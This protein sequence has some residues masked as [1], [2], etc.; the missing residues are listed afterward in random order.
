MSNAQGPRV[1]PTAVI[2]P[3]AELAGD[4]E[5]GPYAI[6]EGRVRVGPG[7]VIR[8][9]ALLCGP[10]TMGQNNQVFTGA[11]LG[12]RPQHLKHNDEP[13]ALEIGDANIFREHVTIHRGTTHSWVTR[14]GSH[15]FFMANSHVAHDCRVGDHCI[16]ANGALVGG[17]CTIEDSVYLSGN[18]AVH[19]FVRVGRLAMLSGCSATSKDIPPFVVQQGHNSVVG[20][21]VI[22]MRRAGYDLQQ[23]NATREAFRILFREG[24]P[25]PSALARLE[26]DLGTV[27]A[28]VEML[29]FLRDCPKGINLMHDRSPGEAA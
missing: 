6:I 2:S 17:H 18:T 20:V 1:H 12:E 14:V 10:L 25:L 29:A 7:C 26:R 8:P 23:I 19:Q 4:V 21:N 9:G 5:V 15:N 22:G 28:V 3:E 27:S 11:V 13:T 24:L 16:F